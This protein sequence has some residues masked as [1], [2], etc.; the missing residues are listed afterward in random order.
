MG[1]GQQCTEVC[2]QPLRTEHTAEARTK[3]GDWEATSKGAERQH[4]VAA[5]LCSWG[6]HGACAVKERQGRGAEPHDVSC[7]HV[8][9]LQHSG[10]DSRVRLTGGGRRLAQLGRSVAARSPSAARESRFM[11]PFHPTQPSTAAA[12]CT[13]HTRHRIR[14][15]QKVRHHR[16]NVHGHDA[17]VHRKVACRWRGSGGERNTGDA[18]ASSL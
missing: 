17:G 11:R 2:R 6:N 14:Q 8:A 3:Q 15:D 7:A 10:S 4:D 9:T 1:T 5:G 12:L 18:T 16:P 13:C